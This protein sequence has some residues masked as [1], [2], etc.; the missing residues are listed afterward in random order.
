MLIPSMKTAI[1]PLNGAVPLSGGEGGIRTHG[2]LAPTTVFEFQVVRV[3]WSI[4]CHPVSSGL[5]C[6]AF[7]DWPCTSCLGG[8]TGELS[9]R[10]TGLSG[11]DIL[12]QGERLSLGKFMLLA[13]R[14]PIAE[15]GIPHF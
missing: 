3:I 15:D 6:S 7:A 13:S 11:S 12:K 5:V 8:L 2:G 4:W 14:A 10:P 1:R 9:A